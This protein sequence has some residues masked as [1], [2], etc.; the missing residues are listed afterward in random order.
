M[1]EKVPEGR[2]RGTS[3]GSWHRIAFNLWRIS[4]P[5]RHVQL[6]FEGR[7]LGTWIWILFWSLVLGASS[8]AA[9]EYKPNIV[10]ILADDLGYG[11]LG[12]Y[13]KDS[14][15]P[16]P[17]LDRLAAEGTRF[18]DAH[19]PTSV[20]TPTRYALLTGRYAWR[21]PL[22]RGVLNPWGATLIAPDRLTVASL[23]RQQGYATACIGKWHLGWKWP[24]KDGQP[25]ASGPDRLSNVDF[26]K[27]IS[28]G[29]TT[30]GFDYYFGTDVPNYPPYCFIENDRTVGLPTVPN[31]PEFNRP[32]PMLPG[33]QWVEIMPELT[34]RAVHYIE[35]AAK[36][37]PRKPFFLYFPL[38]A[39][40]Y[41]VVPAAEFQGRSGAGDYGDFVAQVDWTV[42]QV[43]D[44]LQR[45]GGADNTLVIFTSDNGPEITGEVKNGVYDRAQQY[46]HF[47]M[48]GLRGAKRDAWEGGHRVPFIARWPGQIQPG[49]VSNE[50]I[51][52]VDF[53]AT[54]AALLDVKLADTS[55]EDSWN[56]LPALLGRKLDQ[57]IREATVHHSASGQFAI[58]QGDWVLIQAP[59]GDDN[60]GPT[61]RGEP[62][63]LKQE[64]GYEAH[65][66][67]GELFDLRQDLGERRNLYAELPDKVRELA[68][69]LEKYQRD[70]R[71]TPGAPQ[72]NDVATAAS[73][74]NGPVVP[75]GAKKAKGKA[76]E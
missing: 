25:P 73:N 65:Q 1:G 14:K 39:P 34:R 12:C 11:D 2:L 69:L 46:R 9:A 49:G 58:R 74:A 21:S 68:N 76:K 6:H 15:I 59:S 28:E 60:G 50:T 75:G 53:M 55:G 30:R 18:T 70:G 64:H 5:T 27:P 38:T 51:S 13:N 54:I 35:D 44:A 43:L 7:W 23:L 3:I 63:W 67:P 41:P 10:F 20:C 24:T 62:E 72:Q 57:P 37:S 16:T 29:P 22:K 17:N 32:G 33:W 56:I 66:Q 47:S 40:H 8:F 52:H 19:A 42:G 4:L 26:T 48:G 71:S 31:R 36:T 61:R 45:T